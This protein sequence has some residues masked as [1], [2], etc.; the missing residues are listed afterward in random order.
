MAER[1][2]I[3]FYETIWRWV[4]N[5]VH[6]LEMRASSRTMAMPSLP[7]PANSAAIVAKP[8]RAKAAN[9]R[10]MTVR[11]MPR[12]PRAAADE[13]AS[14]MWKHLPSFARRTQASNPRVTRS[15]PGKRAIGGCA[16]GARSAGEQE[17]GK[18]APVGAITARA[19]MSALCRADVAKPHQSGSKTSRVATRIWAQSHL[20]ALLTS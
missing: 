20:G 16:A 18:G 9:A 5:L 19:A 15:Y 1:G 13:I 17:S 14:L 12:K 6:A 7:A 2:I 3:V 10:A 8:H 4:N 11:A